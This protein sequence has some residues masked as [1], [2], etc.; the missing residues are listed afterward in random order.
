MIMDL[1]KVIA[2]LLDYP[3]EDVANHKEE[4]A[5]KEARKLGYSPAEIKKTFQEELCESTK[6]SRT[7]FS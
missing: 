2:R 5:V 7:L 1:L 3:R 6:P 4:I